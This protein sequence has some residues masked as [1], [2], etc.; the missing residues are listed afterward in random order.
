MELQRIRRPDGPQGWEAQRAVITDLYIAKGL[1]LEDLMKTMED[2]YFFKATRKQ[3]KTHFTKW[4]LRKNVRDFEYDAIIKKKRKRGE[5]GKGSAFRLRGVLVDDS[6]IVR[7]EKRTKRSGRHEIVEAGTPEGLSCFTPPPIASSP[8]VPSQDLP[9]F[10]SPHLL[11]SSIVSTSKKPLLAPNHCLF[12]PKSPEDEVDLTFFE[13]TMPL[14]DRVTWKS[15]KLYFCPRYS[16]S[17]D[18]II[19]VAMCRAMGPS[20]R[21]FSQFRSLVLNPS[22]PRLGSCFIEHANKRVKFSKI[23]RFAL[24]YRVLF[25]KL[26]EIVFISG[27]VTRLK[28]PSTASG[29]NL[30]ISFLIISSD[31]HGSTGAF[32]LSVT[33][34]GGKIV[35][36]VSN[37]TILDSKRKHKPGGRRSE[38]FDSIRS[39]DSFL[40]DPVVDWKELLYGY[41]Q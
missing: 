9:H 41:N 22:L 39:F 33:A 29:I 17:V 4:D 36:K 28:P 32:E 18:D 16:N 23:R 26:Y 25:K 40:S 7:Y 37:L 30:G 11:H 27:C 31:V 19:R 6:K 15:M 13:F 10:Q 34:L 20:E 38:S 21:D 2:D 8:I 1:E 24:F 35:V 3:Y 14:V 5:E 12:S